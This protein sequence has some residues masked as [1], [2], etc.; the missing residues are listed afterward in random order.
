MNRMRLICVAAAVLCLVAGAAVTDAQTSA[1][2][3]SAQR[4]ASASIVLEPQEGVNGTDILVRFDGYGVPALNFALEFSHLPGVR[5]GAVVVEN[6]LPSRFQLVDQADWY[7]ETVQVRLAL[8]EGS[9]P[10]QGLRANQEIAIIH[11]PDNVDVA[12]VRVVSR[13][14]SASDMQANDIPLEVLVAD[15]M[16]RGVG[17]ISADRAQQLATKSGA[18]GRA[19]T[20]AP[21]IDFEIYDPSDGDNGF[22]VSAGGQFTANVL[23]R[24][25][26]DTTTTYTQSCGTVAGG[27]GRLATAVV[28]IAFDTTKLS[29]NSASNVD[30]GDGLIQDNTGEGRIGWAAAGDWEPDATTT[31]TLDDP[32]VMDKLDATVSSEWDIMQLVFDVDGSFT[33]GST[34]LAFRREAD[35]FAF[36]VA[37]GGATVWKEADFDE[38]VDAVVGIDIAV[39]ATNSGLAASAATIP[40]T[41]GTSDLTATVEDAGGS[42]FADQVVDF[43]FLGPNYSGAS[44]GG[45]TDNGDGTYD[46]TLT[47]GGQPGRAKIRYT[48]S[49]CDGTFIDPSDGDQVIIINNLAWGCDAGDANG[50]GGSLSGADGT[51][52]LLELVDGDVNND[53]TAWESAGTYAATPCADANGDGSLSGADGTAL[54]L[55]VAAG[56][57]Q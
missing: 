54:L 21:G 24:P 46:V 35:G 51:A 48:V 10:F 2:I 5:G 33:S 17:V 45:M 40:I 50:S 28:D 42:G 27:D 11:V 9:T 4:A 56:M 38:I 25:G 8:L 23:L 6:L 44:L 36:S 15:T 31:G 55:M 1:R 49:L 12:G 14:T 32:C 34:E 52:I 43:E 30:Y 3:D 53:P 37:D 18:A 26:T 19:T 47:A 20:G 16:P 39:D 7:T 13:N 29:L 57:N 41:T 22:C